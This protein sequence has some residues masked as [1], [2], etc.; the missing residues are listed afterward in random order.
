[1]ARYY[2]YL[3][4]YHH[5]R[6]HLKRLKR[7]GVIF[8]CLLLLASIAI[9]TDILISRH[10]QPRPVSQSDILI[11]QSPINIFRTGYFQFQASPAWAA[12]ANASSANMFVYRKLDQDLIQQELDIY[13]NQ[14]PAI[15]NA[16]YV[17]PVLASTDGVLH[18]QGVSQHCKNAQPSW[19][20]LEPTV[21]T[22]QKVTFTCVPDGTDYTVVAGEVGGTPNIKLRRPDNSLATYTLVFKDVTVLPSADQFTQILN[23]FEAR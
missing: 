7:V 1:M 14:P 22:Y 16:T 17:E 19:A 15:L 23:S 4:N 2:Y 12:I 21:V 8:A 10:N 6:R 18:A 9:V 5:Q 11:Q 13:V 20:R 3:T